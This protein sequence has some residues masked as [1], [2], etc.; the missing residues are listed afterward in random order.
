MGEVL[1]K[2]AKTTGKIDPTAKMANEFAKDTGLDFG[3]LSG[4][5][6]DKEFKA[7]HAKKKAAFERQREQQKQET[8][9][10]KKKKVAMDNPRPQTQSLLTRTI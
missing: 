10:T 1:G 4:M 5:E 7:E 8:T 9:L 3:L 6:R 2:V